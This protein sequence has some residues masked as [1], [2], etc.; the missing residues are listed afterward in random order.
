[1]RTFLGGRA[2]SAPSSLYF[3]MHRL[4]TLR[5]KRLAPLTLP[6]DGPPSCDSSS[7][8]SI[9]DG[10]QD[11]KVHIKHTDGSFEYVPYFCLPGQLRKSKRP[12]VYPSRACMRL[13]C[14]ASLRT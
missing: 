14:V 3:S 9:I 11:Y 7:L 12:H 13:H 4:F 10:H 5:G 6:S 8:P 2:A 1:V